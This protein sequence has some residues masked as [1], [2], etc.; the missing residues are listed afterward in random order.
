MQ[1]S[2]NKLARPNPFAP[3][4]DTLSPRQVKFV[5]EYMLDLHPQ[6]AAIR[7]GYRSATS[8]ATA[9]SLLKLPKIKKAI[10]E[11]LD[12]R[13]YRTTIT[14]DRVLERWWM[15]ATADPNELVQYR[16]VACRYC[17]GIDFRYQWKDQREYDDAAEKAQLQKKPAPLMDGGFGYSHTADPNPECPS[18]CGEGYGRVHIKDTRTLDGPAALLYAGAEEGREGVKLKM[19][20]QAKALENV[21]KHLG[22]FKE[23][24][25]LSGPNGSPVHL[26]QTNFDTSKL[27]TDELRDLERMLSKCAEPEQ[28]TTGLPNYAT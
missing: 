8:Y 4:T 22:M 23:R 12:A 3:P 20:D 27:T 18:C 9:Q 10:Q 11:L 1:S 13:A 21:A 15:I 7:A 14:Q 16:R 24:V 19:H 28:G 17:H 25:E 26:N 2:A 6:N 5:S